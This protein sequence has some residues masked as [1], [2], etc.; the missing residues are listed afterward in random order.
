MSVIQVVCQNCGAKYKLPA[1][2]AAD[3]AK[4]KAC[5]QAIDVA[6]Q[7]AQPPESTAAAP[8]S[9]K[10]QPATAKAQPA[11]ARPTSEPARPARASTASPA[12]RRAK[13]DAGSENSEKPGRRARGEKE[14]KKSGM[15]PAVIGG[16]LVGVGALVVGGI[17]MFNGDKPAEAGKT[18]NPQPVASSGSG[19]NAAN[20]SATKIGDGEN[21]ATP[22]PTDNAPAT[23]DPAGGN[24]TPAATPKAPEAA[25]PTAKPAGA[26]KFET[27]ADIFDPKTLEPLTYPDEVDAAI[28][29]EIDEAVQAID[30]TGTR[31]ARR[32][33]AR[34]EE[35]GY[36]A[37]FGLTNRLRDID[38]TTRDGTILAYEIHRLMELIAKG[39]NTSFK[40][41]DDEPDLETADWNAKGVRTWQDFLRE[42]DTL[43]KY[44]AFQA[45]K[46]AALEK[47]GK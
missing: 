38:Y 19:S 33:K 47:Q 44:E 15:S 9:A 30:G 18:E 31:A 36:P 4:C 2:F 13:G 22:A 5:G 43:E 3:K 6:A 27:K 42:N 11:K 8:V 46:K 14:A 12:S 39:T 17:L 28:R 24:D 41:V 32:A 37:L 34:L 21:P 45:R 25:K 26:P 29:A 16:I 7:R 35:L 1:T 23:T 40:Q 20:E 10:A